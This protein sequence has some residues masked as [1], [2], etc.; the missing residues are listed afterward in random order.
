MHVSH[1]ALLSLVIPLAMTSGSALPT[2]ERPKAGAAP[3]FVVPS[4]VLELA[5]SKRR[6]DQEDLPLITRVMHRAG[7]DDFVLKIDP[8]SGDVS[9]NT[10]TKSTPHLD[11]KPGSCPNPISIRAGDAAATV[12]TGVLGNGFDVTQVDLGSTRLQRPPPAAFLT[13]KQVVPSR[14]GLADVGTPFDPESP[15]D[16]AAFGPDGILDINVQYNKSDVVNILELASE[17]L[18][19]SVPLQVVGITKDVLTVFAAVD[20]VRIQR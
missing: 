18:G 7:V 13:E 16:C 6:F 2:G 19:S 4:E 20:C 15:C 12:S 17:P 9:V 3:A 14:I 5:R 11:I 1:A 8:S 10:E